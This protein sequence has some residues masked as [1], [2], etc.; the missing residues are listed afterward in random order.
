MTSPIVTIPGTQTEEE[1]VEVVAKSLESTQSAELQEGVFFS[2]PDVHDEQ[3]ALAIAQLL[4][5]RLEDLFR[6]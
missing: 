3:E 1:L 5:R 2:F 4:E 6:R